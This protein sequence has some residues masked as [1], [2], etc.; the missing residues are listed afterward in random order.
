MIKWIFDNLNDYDKYKFINYIKIDYNI[1]ELLKHDNSKV[2]DYLLS[3]YDLINDDMIIK[4]Y[5]Y[6][7]IHYKINI[8]NYLIKNFD[9]TK[10]DLNLPFKSIFSYCIKYNYYQ[11]IDIIIKNIHNYNWLNISVLF[12]NNNNNIFTYL[13]T[14]YYDYLTIN[15]D[16]FFNILYT[17]NLKCI[18]IFVD[19]YKGN[20][21]YKNITDDD[22]I[23]LMNY[24]NPKLMNY[25]YSLHK[26][27]F[28]DNNYIIKTIISMNK[29]NILKWI[30]TKFKNE[31]KYINKY[32]FYYISI[33][34]K[35]LNIIKLLYK[36]DNNQEFNDY[37]IEYLTFASCVD[38]LDIFKWFEN[39]IIK[40]DLLLY[41]YNI[42][43]SAITVNNITILKYILDTYDIDINFNDGII[44]R[45]SFDYL[46]NDI[47]KFLF[48]KYNNIDV[49][50]K[51]EII[52]RYAIENAYIDIINLLYNYNNNFNLSI[53][54]EYL[55]RISCKTDNIEVVKWLFEKNNNIDYSLNNH[56]IFYYVCNQNYYEI[57]SF[58]NE[59]N[60]ELYEIE[61]KNY[62][63]ISYQV[64]KKIKITD[65]ISI[66]TIDIC[67]ICLENQSDV[68][69]E[70][71][72]QYCN[73]CINSLNN[74][75][76]FF[77]C[78]LCRSN[79]QI[80]KNIKK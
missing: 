56:E 20:I 13:I 5:T 72:H 27:D 78:A 36:F 67:P 11:V 26:I 68:I 45:V 73:E 1:V 12:D 2:I 23:I 6:A 38:N 54:N 37:N 4:L 30:L 52:M 24:D 40:T 43:N 15:E 19:N 77:I 42:I 31:N 70:C 60:P 48:E 14:N 51:N 3:N 62:E 33:L 46:A 28:Y 25:I 7:F 34:H 80:I 55:F 35:N 47:I 76:E 18:K 69:T 22:Y 63:I 66:D 61:I 32:Y 64:N 71:N 57:A 16:L 49:L 74:K 39:K 21:N 17:G 8:L 65:Y 41:K 10:Y 58:F 59:I 50:V 75:N 29:F 44:I 53:D 79:I 9:I